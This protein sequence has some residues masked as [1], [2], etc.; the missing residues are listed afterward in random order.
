MLPLWLVTLI[1][2]ACCALPMQ[3]GDMVV[4][5]AAAD[6]WQASTPL[7]PALLQGVRLLLTTGKDRV[8]VT[9]VSTEGALDGYGLEFSCEE[10]LSVSLALTRFGRCLLWRLALH[11]T[12]REPQLLEA[13]VELRLAPTGKVTVFDGWDDIE[14]PTA[15]V[16]SERLEGNM[17]LTCCWNDRATVAVGLEPSQLVSYLRSEYEPIEGGARLACITRLVVDPEKAETV[18]FVTW[19]A[20]GEWGKYEA[21]EAYY[22]SFPASFRAHPDVDPRANLGGAQYVTWPAREWSP[23][24]ARRLYCG[25]DWCYAPF[26]RTGDIA[27]RPE[28]WD[29]EPA[30]PFDK[31][32]ALPRDDYLSWRHKTLTDGSGRCDVAMM[33]YIPSQIWCEERLARDKYSEALTT[34][35]KA[36]TYFDTPW[37]T[38]HDNELRVFPLGTSFADQSRKDLE[39]L[40][41]YLPISGFAFDTAGDA[42]R[43]TGPALPTLPYRAWDDQFDAYCGENVAI[44]A[45][46][47]YVHGIKRDGRPLAVVANPMSNG[48]YSACFRADSAMLE[49][50]PWAGTRTQCDRLRWKMG[51]KT[52]VWWEGY[53]L[54]DFVD[55]NTVAAEQLTE[56]YKGLADFTLLQSLR[57][58]Y[59]PPPAYTPGVARLVRWLPA[60]VECVQ[61]GWEPVPAARVPEPLWSSRY[62]KGLGTL[63]A[64]AHETGEPVQADAMIENTRLGMP[65]PGPGFPMMPGTPSSETPASDVAYLFSTYQGDELSNTVRD[66]E[67]GVSLEVPVRTP[68]L[69]RA[70]LAVRP[71]RAVRQAEVHYTGD[72]TRA[73]LETTLSGSG[74]VHVDIR[75]P[76]GM[77]V[78]AARVD[79]VSVP[80]NQWG[81]LG[82]LEVTIGER[83]RLSVEF[84][85]STLALSQEQLFAYPFVRDGRPACTLVVPRGA[86]EAER[87]AAFRLQE[88]FRY[89]YGRA[90][91]P[92]SEVLL[93]ISEEGRE[94]RGPRVTFRAA[95]D[96]PA[97]VSLQG[98]E[99]TVSGPHD[100]SLLPLT[101]AL[102]RALDARYWTA[103]RLPATPLNRRVELAGK[104][105]DW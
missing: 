40:A 90:T 53:D 27:C 17:P 71:E 92:P 37:V 18:S 30:R 70:Q 89:W 23:E 16:S 19:A 74:A 21:F 96:L 44:A 12:G 80:C 28:L 79:G 52:L 86:S 105:I 104:V 55:A 68:V 99:L 67:T 102:L 41:A 75:V 42:R 4:S 95:I 84:T 51:H 20:P 61:A 103:E 69:L 38:G 66:G 39:E 97:R 15:R 3:P 50:N 76:P 72:A 62:G 7:A 47:D 88:Y 91:D 9:F 26:R 29:Y 94:V 54:E 2:S 10:P 63:I 24:I 60:I 25:W 87:H 100:G 35:P 5:P 59:I 33:F 73:T 77:S 6:H 93:P 46:M 48:C 78:S 98:E 34:D 11:N 49:A 83:T 1:T 65:T 64:V 43:Y 85:S 14:G 56:V 45:L 31:T 58:G 81:Q 22:E 36:K 32:R 13:G 57:V 101:L 82:G 8:P